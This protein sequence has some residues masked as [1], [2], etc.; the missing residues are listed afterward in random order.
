MIRHPELLARLREQVLD[1]VVRVVFA[2]LS[3]KKASCHRGESMQEATIVLWLSRNE[4][5]FFV[6]AGRG[7][8]QHPPSLF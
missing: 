3:H 5:A 7:C 6:A 4:T 1:D 2:L 8:G